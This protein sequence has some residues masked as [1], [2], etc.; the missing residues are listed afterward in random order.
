MAAVPAAAGWSGLRSD[1]L[2]R[3]LARLPCVAHRVAFGAVCFNWRSL[4]RKH[5]PSTQLPWLL[6]PLSDEEAEEDPS[7]FCL[8]CRD[9]HRVAL[10][11]D[12]RGARWGGSL[13][14]GW[15][16][17]VPEI[18]N[19]KLHN[20]HTGQCM[21]IQSIFTGPGR[22]SDFG[23]IKHVAAPT[24]GQGVD[25][26]AAIAIFDMFGTDQTIIAFW[27]PGLYSWSTPMVPTG[28]ISD[29]MYYSGHGLEGF[30]VLTDDEELLVYVPEKDP[31]GEFTTGLV[32][33]Y[34]FPDHQATPS[35]PVGNG[36][37][38]R[39]LVNYS[40]ELLM[41][42]RSVSSE[43]ATLAFRVFRLTAVLP[44]NDH[45]NRVASWFEI[46]IPAGEVILGRGCSKF[47]GLS[48]LGLDGFYF[49]D[50]VKSLTDPGLRALLQRYPCTDMGW[51]PLLSNQVDR[52]FPERGVSKYRAVW[53]FH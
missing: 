27:C 16:V 32:V 31:N 10:P 39:Y 7:F 19:C 35:P 45:I 52:I 30:H 53:F 44:A 12:V 8:L 13:P 15:L 6:L 11:E 18:Y 36:T 34:T 1:L 28:T 40:G 2:G 42:V 20:L 33:T 5:R 47:Y 22:S 46:H 51:L 17:L 26:L 29:L 41:V 38:T 23:M 37:I 3:V 48:G 21:T 49:L 25:Y 14:G 4:T 43:G 24:R 50:D 9:A